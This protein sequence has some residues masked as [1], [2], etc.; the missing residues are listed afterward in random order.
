MALEVVNPIANFLGLFEDEEVDQRAILES[1]DARTNTNFLN[2]IPLDVLE[3][4]SYNSEF[5]IT[6]RPVET[7]FPVT[8]SRRRLPTVLNLI[9]VQVTGQS[10]GDIKPG[11]DRTPL[12][13][14]KSWKDKYDE[15]IELKDKQVLITYVCSIDTYEGYLIS[16]LSITRAKGERSDALFFVIG[17][18]ESTFVE[19]QV[20]D[21]DPNMIPRK[22]RNKKT[23]KNTDGDDQGAK[24]NDKGNKDSVE[25]DN[26]TMAKQLLE[27]LAGAVI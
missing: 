23:D 11:T 1:L 14:G 27:G 15:L 8:D 16:S 3:E 25:P 21:I 22:K 17:L 18:K 20:V 9:G 5:E 12:E 6:D 13:E 10:P 7:G 24:K 19:S 4:F 26:R 2:D